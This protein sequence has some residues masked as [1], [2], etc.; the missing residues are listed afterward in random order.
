MTAANTWINDAAAKLDGWQQD[1]Y[2]EFHRHPEL[3]YEEHWTSERIATELTGLG[4]DVTEVGPT[5][6]VTILENGDG[7]VVFGRADIDG[8]P[9]PEESGAQHPSENDGFM[10]ACGHDT[11]I[12]SLIGAVRL[13]HENRDEW[14]GT[15]V[16]VFQPA[17]EVGTGAGSMVEAGMKDAVPEPT[18]VLGQ[19]VM[20]KLD[21]VLQTSPGAVLSQADSVKIVIQGRGAHGSMPHMSVDPVLIASA[22]VMRLQSVVAREVQP[23]TFSVVT[24][25]SIH[26]GSGANIIPDTAELQLNLRHYD[27]TVRDR[28]IAA[29]ERIVRA[30]CEAAGAPKP[31]SIEYFN[32]Y[33]LTENHEEPTRVV[34]EA[35]TEFFGGD[36][37][38]NLEP[39]TGSEDFS[40]I[41]DAFGA[42]YTYW[43]VGGF[44][45]DQNVVREGQAPPNHS[46]QYLPNAKV[47]LP[48][49]TRAMAVAAMA[50]LGKK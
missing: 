37:V 16:A 24:V 40:V 44:T 45:A 2:W 14:A 10:H 5:G 39:L 23:G 3:S 42:P 31:P 48:R 13:L 49:M 19:H 20:P 15:F 4:L 18:V 26:A 50:W 7:P 36:Q 46:P 8:L 25:G 38:E 41:A 22:I 27:T 1:L 17:E 28:V 32:Q 21:G 43:V 47:A 6:L 30:E 9:L 35:F 29:V 12:T 11:H 33:P 34:T